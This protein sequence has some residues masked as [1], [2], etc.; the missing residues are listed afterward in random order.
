MN[1]IYVDPAVSDKVRRERLYDGQLFTFAPRSSTR[2]LCEHARTMI[3][4]AFDGHNPQ[5]AQYSMPAEE[6]LSI[7]ASL[8]RQLAGHPGSKEIVRGMLEELGCDLDKTYLEGPHLHVVRSE[9]ANAAKEAEGP[10]PY[11]DTWCAA[12]MCQVNWWLPVYDIE[13]E[14][15]LVFYPQYWEQAVPNG[16]HA[17]E[18]YDRDGRPEDVRDRP[19]SEEPIEREPQIRVVT[20]AGGLVVFSAAQMHSRTPNT[21]GMMC[22]SIE[23]RTVH[24]DDVLTKRGAENVDSHATGTPLRNFMRSSDLR[25]VPEDVA[26]LYDTVSVREGASQGCEP[27]QA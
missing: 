21:S 14:A 12:P 22:Y 18:Y 16:S 5:T 20:Q 13:A 3:E 25:R 9:R 19:T 23:C 27:T 8:K 10:H 2:V 26:L 17:F 4:A 1:T 24:I 7:I 6:Y 15:A 11:R